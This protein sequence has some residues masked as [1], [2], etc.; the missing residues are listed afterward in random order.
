MER[1]GLF[2]QFSLWNSW[3][4][5]GEPTKPVFSAEEF[6]D[7]LIELGDDSSARSLYTFGWMLSPLGI[8]CRFVKKYLGF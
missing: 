6:S 8:V 3:L 1:R 5:Q 7:C 4:F 2:F